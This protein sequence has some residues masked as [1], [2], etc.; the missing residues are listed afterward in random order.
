[1]LKPRTAGVVSGIALVGVLLGLYGYWFGTLI[2]QRPGHL[3]ACVDS[4]PGFVAWHC[5]R[6]LRHV[7][8]GAEAVNELNAIAG[9][10]L[11][12]YLRDRTLGLE[13]AQAF[14]RQGVDVDAPDMLHKRLT[15]LH[16]AALAADVAQARALMALGASAD[17]V[18]SEGRTPL[19]IATQLASARPDDARLRELV[20][21]LAS[22]ST[23]AP[24]DR[25]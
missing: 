5:E 15:A 13:L 7:P 23:S 6:V 18:D 24:A 3:L 12:L 10:R 22:A 8:L 2:Q 11:P 17:I 1:M 14:I 16:G 4:D 20:A 9:V 21:L 25:R 19:G